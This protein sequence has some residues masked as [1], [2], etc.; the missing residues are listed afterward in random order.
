MPEETMQDRIDRIE[1][2]IA[3][4][5]S[6]CGRSRASVNLLPVSKTHGPK[7]IAAAAECGLSVFG[8]NRIQEAQRKIPLCSGALRWHFIGHLQTNKA[9]FVPPLFDMVHSLDSPRLMEA[10]EKACAACGRT[11]PVTLEVNVAGE[12]SKFGMRPEEV[13]AAVEQADALPHLEPVGL[14][15]I[16]PFAEDPEKTRR[17]F[18]SLRELRDD[19]ARRSGI[20]LPELSMGMSHDFEVAIE[21][22][23]TWVRVGTG[24]FGKRGSPWKP[25]SSE[26]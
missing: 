8:E 24:I 2:R 22:G 25:D 6:R 5:C 26:N 20:E 16:P 15:T 7:T 1:E 14:M 3:A 13:P 18:V 21:E 12:G 11:L 23:A 4:A 17:H 10:L 19:C 9:R